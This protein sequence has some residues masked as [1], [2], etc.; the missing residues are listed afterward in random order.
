MKIS[1]PDTDLEKFRRL[2]RLW[3][4]RFIVLAHNPYMQITLAQVRGPAKSLVAIKYPDWIR[5]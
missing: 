3:P 1:V 2:Q 4:R 5:Q